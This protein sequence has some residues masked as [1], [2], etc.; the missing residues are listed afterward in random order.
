MARFT[1]AYQGHYSILLVFMN[2]LHSDRQGSVPGYLLSQQHVSGVK[3]LSYLV[4][5]GFYDG[6]LVD[7]V[8]QYVGLE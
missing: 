6:L 2:G 1:T 7:C 5:R 3:A 4:T 8:L